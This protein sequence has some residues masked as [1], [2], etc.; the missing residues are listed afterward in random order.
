MGAHVPRLAKNLCKVFGS[1]RFRP[2]PQ[3]LR[4]RAVRSARET[5]NLKVVFGSNPTSATIGSI[6]FSVFGFLYIVIKKL[7]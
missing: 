5:H 1:I 6:Q 7:L 2:F 4:S 3:I